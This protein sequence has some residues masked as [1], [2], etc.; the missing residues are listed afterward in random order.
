MHFAFTDEQQ[1]I[2]DTARSFVDTHGDIARVRSALESSDGFDRD[3]WKVL[4]G[5]L[6]FGGIAI[7]ESYGGAGLGHIELA[8]V[9]EMLGRTLLPS[10]FFTSI[11]LAAT[12]I[13]GAGNES[14]K[15]GL[16][17]E[18][19]SGSVIATLA[20]FGEQGGASCEDVA[21]TLSDDNTLSGSA[22]FVQY[23]HVADL[24]VFAAR[25][26]QGTVALAALPAN[27]PGI[28]I[29][30]LT[31]MDLT[32]PMARIICN[33]VRVTAEQL[34]P[35]ADEAL[36][37]A[38][39]VGAVMIA[40][41]A[42]GS[43]DAILEITTAYT[44]E[45]VQFGRAIGSFQAIKHR[46]ADMMVETEAARSLAWYAACTIDEAPELLNEAASVAKAGCASA[47]SKCAGDMIQLHGGIGFTWE[48]V[49]HLYFK[50]ARS[51]STT[52]G[53][54]SWHHERIMTEIEKGVIG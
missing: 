40:S 47:L 38:L 52:L 10:P 37:K 17:P 35:N 11:G 2:R 14:Q 3:S 29:E 48:H 36:E 44:K 51:N 46:L 26:K 53:N 21:L 4:T 28:T 19:A 24:I 18:I 25:T 16:L 8:S 34:M 39:K 50:R 49:A 32:R 45:R 1:M 20:C 31:M 22:C 27:T 30:P 13:L 42:L 12:A 43:C 33:D 23:G 6:G 7:P 41:D 9:H 54:T 15:Q 5:E